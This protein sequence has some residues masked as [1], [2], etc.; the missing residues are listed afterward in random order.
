MNGIVPSSNGS[1]S[2]T[3]DSDLNSPP[4]SIATSPAFVEKTS[5]FESLKSNIVNLLVSFLYTSTNALSILLLVAANGLI[6]AEVISF[7]PS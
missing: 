7:S 5:G 1:L 3:Y 6:A 2:S 4:T